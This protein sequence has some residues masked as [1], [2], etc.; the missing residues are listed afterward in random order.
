MKNILRI[1]LFT[2]L[3]IVMATVSKLLFAD[4]IEW[5]G[6]SPLIATALFSGMIIKDKKLSFLLPL[7]ALFISDII[8]QILYINNLF[9]FAGLYKFQLVNYALLLSATL[10]GW[11]LK[12]KNIATVGLGAVI[13]PTV[14]FLLS[15]LVVWYGSKTYPQNFN[16][17]MICY[18]AGLPF[19]KHALA[20]T[21]IFLPTLILA[22]NYIVKQKQSANIVLR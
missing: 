19:Y 14:F 1:S 2:L 5:S 9:V 6:F 10:I 17:L 7:V 22:Y 18:A 8:I 13:A 16:G 15:N 11:A 20:A 4:K 21:L 12:G 3:V